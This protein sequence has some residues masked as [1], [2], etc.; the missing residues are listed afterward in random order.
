MSLALCVFIVFMVVM[1]GLFL[2][3]Q[4]LIQGSDTIETLLVDFEPDFH[5]GLELM[6]PW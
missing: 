2:S 5:F 3:F 1:V 6:V 4:S